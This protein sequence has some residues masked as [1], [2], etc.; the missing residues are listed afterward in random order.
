MEYFLTQKEISSYD[1]HI[2]SEF[3]RD[4]KTFERYLNDIEMNYGHILTIKKSR[5]KFWRMVTV[6]DVFL[7]FVKNSDEITGLFLMAQEFDPYIFKEIEKGTLSKLAKNDEDVF[8][9]KNSI[10]EELQST[11]LKKVFKNLKVAI[12]NHEYRDIVYTY[13]ERVLCENEKCLKLVFMDNNWYVVVVSQENRLLFRR[14]SFI[15]EV[16]YSSS[17][18]TYAK[19]EVQPHLEFLK[20]IQNAMTLYDV[21]PKI[22]TIK[23]TPN[24][25]KYFKKEM[26]C[27]LPSQHFLKEEP[28]GSVLFTL[29][30][31]QELEVLPLIQ[32]WLPDLIILEPL[33]LKE[34][35]MQKLKLVFE[36]HC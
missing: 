21:A 5:K 27:F 36:N 28:D 26:K 33:E 9:F 23:A 22:A 11:K 1:E 29:E 16:R 17:K 13:D 4:R 24:I 3:G 8:L 2:L 34:A 31:T 15:D 10:M 14:L 6:S 35:Y 30:Y 7:E 18:I 19:R 32:K 20:N 12:A 25:A